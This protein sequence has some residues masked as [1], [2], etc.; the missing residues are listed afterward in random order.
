MRGDFRHVGGPGFS[1]DSLCGER[2]RTAGFQRGHSLVSHRQFPWLRLSNL[3]ASLLHESFDFGRFQRTG[4]AR[5][6]DQFA[7]KGGNRTRVCHTHPRMHKHRPAQPGFHML[8]IHIKL[9]RAIAIDHRHMIPVLARCRRKDQHVGKITRAMFHD[10]DA[11]GGNHEPGPGILGTKY[12][13]P[14]HRIDGIASRIAARTGGC[15]GRQRDGSPGFHP[16]RHGEVVHDIASHRRRLARSPE[17]GKKFLIAALERND[18]IFFS[19]RTENDEH[20]LRRPEIQG[21]FRGSVHHAPGGELFGFSA[22]RIPAFRCLAGHAEAADQLLIALGI[23]IGD[24]IDISFRRPLVDGIDRLH[25]SLA[26]INFHGAAVGIGEFKVRFDPGQ[27]GG[28]RERDALHQQALAHLA[29]CHILAV[30]LTP[31]PGSQFLDF[32]VAICAIHQ[33]RRAVR[34]LGG[35]NGDA[36]F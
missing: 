25:V 28:F 9:R 12:F 31:D 7:V 21:Q 13:V 35:I 19:G 16:C 36:T 34:A 10:R 3:A 24:E 14:R 32:P 26:L 8:P 2:S 27:S 23:V 33:S 4:H 30:H 11:I 15:L 18:R 22:D 29:A 20:G 6:A 5:E 17:R 1:A